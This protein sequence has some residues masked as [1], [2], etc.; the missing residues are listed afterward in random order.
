MDRKPIFVIGLPIEVDHSEFLNA[1]EHLQEDYHILIHTDDSNEFKCQ[2]FSDHEIDPIQLEVLKRATGVNEKPET[3]KVYI[4]PKDQLSEKEIKVCQ[5]ISDGLSSKEIGEKVFLS[6][7]TIDTYRRN[8]F[9]KLGV[10]NVA[11][12]IVKG[13]KLGYI[14]I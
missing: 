11:Q 2:V 5:Y 7:R 10:S 3:G 13:I 14:K 12:L 4:N 9:D 8:I 1:A 6:K